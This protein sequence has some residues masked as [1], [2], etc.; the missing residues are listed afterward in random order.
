VAETTVKIHVC[1]WFRCTGK[2]MGQVYQ[3]ELMVFLDFVHR[4]VFQ[5]AENTTFRKLDLFP[6]SGEGGRNTY[7]LGSSTKSSPQSLFLRDRSEQMSS[8]PH[9]RTETDPVSETLSFLD[10]RIP[11]DV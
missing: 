6:S 3:S 2:A 9:L 7:S 1:C 11:D 4:P 5:E 10:S 8:S